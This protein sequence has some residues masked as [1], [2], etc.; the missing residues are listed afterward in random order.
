M[1]D[2]AQ[3]VI[4]GGG[5][6]GCCTAYHLARRG[7]TD[8]VILEK[9]DLTS[10]STRHAAGL[11]TQFHTTL[12]MM[13]IRKYSVDLYSDFY[14]ES[15]EESGWHGTGSVRL[16]SSHD[17]L[18]SLKQAVSKARGIG[19]DIELLGP[20]E[21]QKLWPAI[22]LD[23]V[24][25]S[26][27]LPDDGWVD[28]HA[29][30]LYMAKKAQE[31]GVTVHTGVRVEDVELSSRRRVKAVVTD[32]GRIECEQVLNAAGMWAGRIADM[33]G[34]VTPIVPVQHQHLTTVPMEDHI[35]PANTPVLRDP[36][37]LCYLREEIEGLLIGGMETSPLS[38]NDRGVPWSHAAQ[39]INSNWELYEPI[40]EG[41]L[42]G[43][44]VLENADVQELVNHPDGFTPDAIPCVGPSPEVPGF[45]TGA[46]MSFNGFASGAGMGRELADWIVNGLPN[47]DMTAYDVRR[48]GEHYRAHEYVVDRCR[49]SYKYYYYLKFPLDEFE[50]GR[51]LRTSCLYERLKR[52]GAVF[53]EKNGMERA[54]YFSP[55][56]QWNTEGPA[57][58]QNFRWNRP[59]YFDQVAAER[60]CPSFR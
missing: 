28:P 48:F 41:A 24:A 15:G 27:Y 42:R 1:K 5:V 21:T 47:L 3:I 34:V 14:M 20:E 19:L 39:T 52:E 9:H 30:T 38:W 51:P 36:D 56:K 25:G 6:V 2:R 40:M 31:M 8:V 50:W 10:G 58:R 44:P 49:E 55:D 26:I 22:S 54:N 45:W 60:G 37:N 53:G 59:D 33:V 35:F 17:Q 16:A 7:A 43:V 12:T 13:Q 18:M 11:V 32:K 23:G 57:Q 46:G 29:V 4:I